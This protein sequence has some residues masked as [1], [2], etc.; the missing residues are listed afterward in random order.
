MAKASKKHHSSSSKS[1]KRKHRDSKSRSTTN[2]SSTS[3]H[4][5]RERSRHRDSD[6]LSTFA[7]QDHPSGV[8]LPYPEFDFPRPPP[9]PR[10][11]LD[12]PRAP[13]PVIVRQHGLYMTPRQNEPQG[14]SYQKPWTGPPTQKSAVVNSDPEKGMNSNYIDTEVSKGKYLSSNI[15]I[16]I[17]IPLI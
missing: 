9:V 7:I 12:N 3:G 17:L 13:Q 2:R 1:S 14:I 8:S 6:S 4:R 10:V 16:S 11:P 15:Y 5:H